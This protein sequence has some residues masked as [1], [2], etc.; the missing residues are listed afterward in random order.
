MLIVTPNER[1]NY[2]LPFRMNGHMISLLTWSHQQK[3]SPCIARVV[4]DE[5]KFQATDAV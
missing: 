1:L 5:E 2:S 3:W 4:D